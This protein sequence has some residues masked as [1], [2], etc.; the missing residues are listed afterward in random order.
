M[1]YTRNLQFDPKLLYATQHFVVMM[2][3]SM[4]FASDAEP[5]SSR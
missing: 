2:P 1:S 3:K 5:P 4:R